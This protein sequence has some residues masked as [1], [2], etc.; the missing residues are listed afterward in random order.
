MTDYIRNIVNNQVVNPPVT[1]IRGATILSMDDSVGNIEHG[2]ILISG[3]TIT[4]VGQN[5]NGQDAHVIDATNMIVM[6]GMVDSHR[7]SW[8][9]QLRRIN[10]NATCL[11]DYSNATHFSFAKYYRPADIYVG[12][13]LTAL[14]AIDAGITTV[15]DNSHN[16]RTAAHSDAAVEA[17]L[18]SGIRAIHA[19]GAPVSGEWDRAHWPGN[20]QRLQ[21][22]YFKNNPEGLVTLGVMAQ[23]EPEL[24]AEARRLELPIVTEFFGAEMASELESLHQQGLLGPDNIFNHCTSLPDEGWKILREAG[25]RVN[26]CPRSDAH[27]GIEDG[28]YAI[29]AA[30]RHGISPGLSVDNETSYSTDMFME[31]RVAFYLQRV[32]GMHQQHCCDPAHSL[33]TLPAAQLL[34][35][36]TVDGAA[37]AGL[38]DKVGSLTPGKQA[39]LILINAGDINLYPSGNAFGTVVHAT[40]R[41]NI[42]TVMIGGRI[43]KQNGKVLGVDSTRL[44]A[45]I[46]ESHEHLF[47]AAG[48]EPDIFAETFLPLK[49]AH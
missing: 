27:Y 20:W 15:I 38:Q 31:M 39:D 4:A 44:R 42:D 6:P 21:E 26:V 7:H 11:D 47:T 10:P 37:C 23:L 17:L 46:D 1:L 19:S 45:A 3:S 49:Q 9:G 28:M 33:K 48:Y 32:M 8:E 14:G 43:V 29:E 5:L 13:L 25:V 18:D 22:K 2:D 12:N 34:K 30:H 16:S 36:A 24:W 41:S 35:A 40:E